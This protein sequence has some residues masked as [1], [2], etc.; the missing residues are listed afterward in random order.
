MTIYIDTHLITTH[1]Y[2]DQIRWQNILEVLL[3]KEDDIFVTHTKGVNEWIIHW[4]IIHH[5]GYRIRPCYLTDYH[6]GEIYATFSV[7][8]GESISFKTA[9]E[10]H[11]QI[12]RKCDY[13]Y[14]FHNKTKSLCVICQC[15]RTKC[16][17]IAV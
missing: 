13:V 3:H 17:C 4:F 16:E 10:R 9:I 6:V 2:E 15:G 5:Q 11:Q 12:G 7:G 1:S 8:L 14:I